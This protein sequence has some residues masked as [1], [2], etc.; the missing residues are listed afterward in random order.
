LK[1]DE[2]KRDKDR[3]PGRANHK[4][5]NSPD[6]K[7]KAPE[8]NDSGPRAKVDD[9]DDKDRKSK[10][11][12]STALKKSKSENDKNRGRNDGGKD[13][14]L[15][16]KRT[17]APEK[18]T[19]TD[20]PKEDDSD[21]AST[22]SDI[23]VANW[24][25]RD[26]KN[27]QRRDGDQTKER[28]GQRRRDEEKPDGQRA[29]SRPE[30]SREGQDDSDRASMVSSAASDVAVANWNER[31][32]VGNQ[33]RGGGRARGRGNLRGRDRGKQD[34]RKPTSQDGDA[35]FDRRKEPFSIDRP[36]GGEKGKIAEKRSAGGEF[37]DMEDEGNQRPRFHSQ[38]R[39]KAENS[40][41]SHFRSMRRN[42]TSN[43]HESWSDF[44]HMDIFVP[45]APMLSS[46]VAPFLPNSNAMFLAP[47]FA[48][49]R[50]EGEVFD[51]PTI[52]VLNPDTSWRPGVP[53]L[54][55]SRFNG[56]Y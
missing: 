10:G 23:A 15:P 5:A 16:P 21:Q 7:G 11:R 42:S 36:A 37:L 52:T 56:P 54:A 6:K 12:E 20:R 17:G 55:T 50:S 48:A 8:K 33:R 51:V 25:G 28:R 1:K 46:M 30:E 43:V 9:K 44:N 3:K 4:E 38:S 24:K 39:N 14:G 13:V 18:L 27:N 29:N 49:S 53:W 32:R 2:N 35:R 34:G 45:G 40:Q 26:R 19:L 41:E 31:E 22:A 47:Q